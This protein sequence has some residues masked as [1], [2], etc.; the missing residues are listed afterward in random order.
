MSHIIGELRSDLLPTKPARRLIRRTI[1]LGFVAGFVN[2]VGFFD[3]HVYPCIMTGNTV[4]L[5][6][7]LA[8]SDWHLFRVRIYLTDQA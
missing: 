5:G 3:L 1:G 4:Q 2:T 8:R 7:S 6:I